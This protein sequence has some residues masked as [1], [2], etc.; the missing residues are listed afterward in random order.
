MRLES[1]NGEAGATYD[2][3][4]DV[5]ITIRASSVRHNKNWEDQ[6]TDNDVIRSTRDVRDRYLDCSIPNLEPVGERCICVDPLALAQRSVLKKN[7]QLYIRFELTPS[8]NPN[9]SLAVSRVS[10]ESGGRSV[11]S[12]FCIQKQSEKGKEEEKR[13]PHHVTTTVSPTDQ[14]VVDAGLV[15]GGS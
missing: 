9:T 7:T 12:L 11:L 10:R 1:L 5:P 3:F 15:T 6:R 4:P 8:S 13:R 14:T 2:L